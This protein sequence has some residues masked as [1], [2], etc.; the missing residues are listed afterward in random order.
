MLAG[1]KHGTNKTTGGERPAVVVTLA[2]V[3]TREIQR[4]VEVVG[5]FRGLEEVTITP[6]VEGRVV[7]IHH[8]VGDMV[9]PGDVLMDIDP[10]DYKLAVEERQGE[11]TPN[12]G[13]S[14]LRTCP[15][16]ISTSRNT[17]RICPRSSAPRT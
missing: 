17:S 5:S 1:C 15:A 16:T 12:C 3:E 11:L 10:T 7:K 4:V 8:D 9:A 13:K 2:P 6:K 14:T